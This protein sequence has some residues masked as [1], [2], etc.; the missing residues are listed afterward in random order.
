MSRLACLLVLFFCTVSV[1][2]ETALRPGSGDAMALSPQNPSGDVPLKI[3][4]GPVASSLPLLVFISG[5]GGWNSFE[6]SLCKS[7]NQKGV[8]LVV[9]DAQKYFW[10]SKTPDETAIDLQRVVETWQKNWN[11]EQF[12]L[13]G[14]SFGASVVPFAVNR[15]TES[16]GRKLAAA[17]LISPD[18]SCDFEIHLSDMLNVVTTRGKFDVLGEIRSGSFKKLVAFFGNEERIDTRNAFE[19]AGAS[20]R[21]LPGNHHFDSGFD[22]LADLM[23]AEMMK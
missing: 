10:K 9:L 2:S 8:S 17:I 1:N 16:L 4:A 14:F 21:L 11:K 20:I 7:L 18:K 23:V 15:F 3:L 6:E 12:V 22:A 5:D 19:Q 13:A